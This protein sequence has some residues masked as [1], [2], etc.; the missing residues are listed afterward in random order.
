M[1]NFDPVTILYPLFARLREDGFNL[2]IDEYM[3][4]LETIN[5]DWKTDTEEDFKTVLKLLWCNSLEEQS[6]LETIWDDT[7]KDL[8]KTSDRQKD[9]REKPK[10]GESEEPVVPDRNL[11][12]EVKPP[13]NLDREPSPQRKTQPKLSPLP[14]K[15]PQ[16]IAEKKREELELKS[17]LPVSCRE[18]V[19]SWRYLRRLLADGMPDV[20]DVNA[21]VEKT[22]QQG[23]FLE[24]VF[25]R[26]LTNHAHLLLLIDREGS[27][28][29]FHRFTNDLVNTARY[30]SKIETVDVGYFHNVPTESIYQDTHLNQP[31]SFA[32]VLEQCDDKTSVLIVSDAGAARGYRRIERIQATTETLFDIQEYTNSIAW[33][34]PM[35]KKRWLR[36]SASILSQ[37]VPMYPLNKEGLNQAIATVQ[38]KLL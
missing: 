2:G 27:M 12:N 28:T 6:Y 31:V 14:L 15:T 16:T 7:V 10:Q 17:E 30:E 32:R 24:P 8:S 21:T 4:V 13:S 22:A 34:N 9:I 1:S 26:R 38:G 20:L 33:L 5:G 3:S 18:M 35:P 11:D 37:I 23:F 25:K 19:Y 29:P 36:T